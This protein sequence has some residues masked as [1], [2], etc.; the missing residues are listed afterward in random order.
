ME[1]LTI[2]YNKIFDDLKKQDRDSLELLNTIE[3]YNIE[4]SET[5]TINLA[6]EFLEDDEVIYGYSN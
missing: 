1:T 3:K 6:A 2:K 5:D 4:I